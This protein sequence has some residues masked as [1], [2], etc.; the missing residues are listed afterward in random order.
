[1]PLKD[2]KKII[3]KLKGNKDL[4]KKIDVED[5]EYITLEEPKPEPVVE[6]KEEEKEKEIVEVVKEIEVK[7]PPKLF[8]ARLRHP[9]DMDV[10]K[11][12]AMNCDIM[13]LNVEE[14]P[15]NI[16]NKEFADLKNYLNTLNFN[17]GWVGENVLLVFKND[18]ELYKHV[19]KISEDAEEV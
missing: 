2:L 13:I 14:L 16:L 1:M 9:A 12:N 5:E 10:V 19:S 4:P 17:M 7:V 6:E 11:E 18:V 3:R 15:E 8:V